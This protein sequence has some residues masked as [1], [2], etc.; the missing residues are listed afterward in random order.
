[1]IACFAT[2]ASDGL[3]LRP[4]RVHPGVPPARSG[5]RRRPARIRGTWASN[6]YGTEFSLDIH[7]HRGAGAYICG[8]ETGL[9]ESLEGKRGLAADQAAVPGDRGGVPQA[10]GHQQRRDALLRP[11]RHRPRGRLVQVAGDAQELR[12]EAVLHLGARQQAGLRRAAARGDGQRADRRTTAAASGRGGRPRRR[13]PAGSAWACSSSTS[14]TPSSTS[15]TSA[16]PAAS[17]WGRRPSPILDDHTKIMDYL[18]N[19]SRFFAHESCGQCTPCREGTGWMYKTIKRI[20]AGGGRPEDLDIMLGMANNDG[21]DAR[22][23]DLR[24]RRRRRLADQERAGQVPPRAGRIHPDAPVEGGEIVTPL[25]Q[26]IAAGMAAARVQ[27]RA[28]PSSA[29]PRRWRCTRRAVD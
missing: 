22:D 15:R 10:D 6:I 1:M 27:R 23:D 29:R 25:Q 13:S 21:P 5:R 11:A 17:A 16:R 3:H 8:E 4:V 20:K 19:T 24:A 12:D 7:V 26:A 9:I 2:R 28:S 14:S 18:Y